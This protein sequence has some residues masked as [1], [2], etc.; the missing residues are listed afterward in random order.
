[1]AAL[2]GEL[3]LPIIEKVNEVLLDVDEIAPWLREEYLYAV[4]DGR[5]IRSSL[6]YI[7]YSLF[8]DGE[9]D[10]IVPIAAGL[11]LLH[12]ASL[13]HDDLIDEDALRRARPT[14]HSVYGWKKAVIMG[15]FLVARAYQALDSAKGLIP[16]GVFHEVRELFTTTF[17]DLSQGELYELHTE[18]D[19]QQLSKAWDIVFGK[20]ASLFSA[21][22]Q[23]G[24]ILAQANGAVQA[25]LGR[26]GEL[27]GSVF[28]IV[29]DLNNFTELE[30]DLKGR[31]G[32]DLLHGKIN[33]PLLE[34]SRS[35]PEDEFR[36]LWD[37]A[38]SLETEQE[39][40]RQSVQEIR[41]Q[42]LQ[43]PTK[44]RL[45]AIVLECAAEA[46]QIVGTFPPGRPRILL[47]AA[48]DDVIHTWFWVSEGGELA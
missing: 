36:V 12:K 8:N 29:N 38:V 27:M 17:Q 34:L 40:R 30:K 39:R 35:V 42:I 45:E 3:L 9:P 13:V 4:T 6:V 43:G 48:C 23:A 44:A 10:V 26:Y 21:T 25:D 33:V 31:M 1:M 16:G 22:L 32:G 15:D 19:F 2:Y 41:W 5:R 37:Q 20:T 24:A 47:E 11:E 7:G 28:Q 18:G 46:K 14:F